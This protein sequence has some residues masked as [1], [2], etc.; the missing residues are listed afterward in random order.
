[1]ATRFALHGIWASGPTYKV[2]L[3]LALTGTPYDYEHVDM[4]Q[5]GHKS[6]EHLARNRYGSVPAL[7]DREAGLC[8]AQSGA[9]LEYL[10]EVTGKFRPD[11]VADRARALEW[12]LWGWDRLARGVYRP[13]SYKLGFQRASDE[14]KAHYDGEG[15]AA[16]KELD[17]HLAGREWL[18]GAA[19]S[20]ADVDLYG[21]VA[22]APQSGQDLTG[23]ANVAG[24]MS[25]IE[26]L[27]G[28]AD[29]RSLL[30]KESKA[31]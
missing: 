10:A 16:L 20:W 11:N 6:P 7:E 4:L 9:S 5:G 12:V 13:R 14:V 15:A 24:W 29:V 26:A 23:L 17:A 21:V 3:M 1:M 25:R 22:Y 31:A 19:P 2:G 27:P 28:F 30:P 18:V 8:L